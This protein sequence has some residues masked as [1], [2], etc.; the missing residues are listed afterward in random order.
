VDSHIY[1]YEDELASLWKPEGVVAWTWNCG[2][3]DAGLGGQVRDV[4]D[5]LLLS[6]KRLNAWS[7][8]LSLGAIVSPG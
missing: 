4:I 7:V 1:K 5:G 3:G 6:S 8:E 2:V